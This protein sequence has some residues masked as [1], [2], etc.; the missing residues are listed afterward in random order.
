[1]LLAHRILGG[2]ILHAT[3]Q[4]FRQ[5][6][7]GARVA[8]DAL[9]LQPRM[10]DRDAL[11]IAL[12][13]VAQLLQRIEHEVRARSERQREQ[14]DEERQDFSSV[15]KHAFVRSLLPIGGSR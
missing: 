11:Q 4:D 12:V 5:P 3:E 13:R 1:M 7:T 10:T 9:H 15:Q 6:A 14:R 8:H 2:E